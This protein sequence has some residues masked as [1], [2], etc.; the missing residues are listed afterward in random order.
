MS[1]Q[2]QESLSFVERTPLL[3]YA[4][5]LL[6]SVILAVPLSLF[7][8]EAG[9]STSV[10][11]NRILLMGVALVVAVVAVTLALVPWWDKA[12]A[13]LIATHLLILGLY[14][15][16][17]VA[18]TDWTAWQ[19]REW[20]QFWWTPPLMSGQIQQVLKLRRHLS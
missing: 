18:T 4:C 12:A 20:W 8:N 7:W 11:Q 9:A 10:L 13:W 5:V 2:L 14:L 17:A 15:G 1:G 19:M 16:L 3:R 6:V